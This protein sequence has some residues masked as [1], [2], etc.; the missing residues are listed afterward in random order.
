MSWLRANAP[1]GA[2]LANDGFADAGIWAPYKAG[3]KILSPRVERDPVTANA[4]ALVGTNLLHLDETPQAAEAACA[5]GVKYLY[6]GAKPSGWDVRAFPML[7]NLSVAPAVQEV[8]HQGDAV[9]FA[10]RLRCD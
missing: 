9:V 8:F 4:R 3:V 7:E 5:L 2:I 1:P 6:H 10:T